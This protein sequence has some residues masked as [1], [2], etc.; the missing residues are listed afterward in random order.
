MGQHKVITFLKENKK[1][2]FTAR[3][4]ADKFK[5]SFCSITITMNLKKLRQSKQINYKIIKLDTRIQSGDT[6]PIYLTNDSIHQAC[7]CLIF[8][9][10]AGPIFDKGTPPPHCSPA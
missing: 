8:N 6:I 2:W 5:A 10:V 1:K 9:Q 4:I 3:Q 7:L